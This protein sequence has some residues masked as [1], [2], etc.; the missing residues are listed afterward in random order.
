MR[1]LLVPLLFFL[2]R[3]ID[4]LAQESVSIPYTEHNGSKQQ[5]EA[6]LRLPS[7]LTDKRAVIVLHHAGGWLQGTTQQY[8]ELFQRNGVISLDLKMFDQRPDNPQKHL[9]QVFG[10]VNYLAAR[11]DVDPSK[12]SV[13]GLSYGGAISLYAATAWAHSTY[14]A[15]GVK[16]R[17]V[18]ALYPTCFF[19]D[20]L[21]K[22]EPRMIRRMGSFGFPVDFYDRWSGIPAKIYIGGKD[23]YESQDPLSCS[24]FVSAVKDEAQRKLFAVE[25]YPEA[26]HGWD[27]GR[28]YSFYEP[29]ACKGR[30][31]QNTNQSD[32]ELTERVKE[33]LLEFLK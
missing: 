7:T 32:P 31:C 33:N 9:A 3:P 14:A 15:P 12:I 2:L 30:G 19:H 23:D 8:G 29:V 16:L 28:T 10:A 22:G 20:G 25:L 26:K 11:T 13:M 21:A 4:A 1:I 5:V 18:A 6:V 24:S 17:S 27:H